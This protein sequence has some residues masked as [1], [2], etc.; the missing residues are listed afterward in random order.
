[1]KESRS[2]PSFFIFLFRK[3]RNVNVKSVRTARAAN[4]VLSRLFRQTDHTFASFASTVN[5]CFSV[6]KTVT[7]EAEKSL[8]VL[9]ET[10]KIR[11]FFASFIE[12]LR[13]QPENRI[14]HN[15]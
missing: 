14:K 9:D 3:S 8:E 11:I 5:V 1:M 10:Q 4:A 7:L 2:F 15:R 12:I 13:K 6:A